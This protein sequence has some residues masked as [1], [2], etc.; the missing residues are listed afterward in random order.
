[1]EKNQLIGT[2]A[3]VRPDLQDDAAKQ[4]GEVGVLTYIDSDNKAYMSFPKGG[5]GIY[6]PKDLLQL[7][8]SPLLPAAKEDPGL[9]LKDYKSLYTIDLLQG[10]GRSTDLL[11]ALE[12][13][14][15]NPT[16]WDKALQSVESQLE[17]KQSHAYTR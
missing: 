16:V 13:A 10:M 14:A 11:R 8:T 6:E 15:T 7:R 2:L 3:L 9:S 4:Q 12:V 1:M 5:E 17:I